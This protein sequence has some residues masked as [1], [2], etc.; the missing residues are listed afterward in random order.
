MKAY[1]FRLGNFLMTPGLHPQ[2]WLHTTHGLREPRAS[3]AQ[4][5]RV[6]RSW[7]AEHRHTPAAGV[8]QGPPV[9]ALVHCTTQLPPSLYFYNLPTKKKNFFFLFFTLDSLI[10]PVRIKAASAWCLCS[11]A[12]VPWAWGGDERLEPGLAVNFVT[13]FSFLNLFMP[14]FPK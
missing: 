12:G 10:L 2:P 3:Q 5:L 6:S 9:W 13:F 1:V 14:F 11:V 8:G 7:K 4:L